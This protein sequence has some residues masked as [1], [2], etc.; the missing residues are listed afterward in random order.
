LPA[1]L[2]ADPAVRDL[3]AFATQAEIDVAQ[4]IYRPAVPQGSQK[5]YQFDRGTMERRWEEGLADAKRTLEASPWQVKAPPGTGM[6]TFDVTN[7]NP[8]RG[9]TDGTI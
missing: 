9:L 4:L 2:A 1:D 7:P 8:P 3:E 5:D 6:R